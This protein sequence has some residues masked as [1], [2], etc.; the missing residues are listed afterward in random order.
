MAVPYTFGTA[1][2]AIPLSNLDSNFATT[3]TLGNTAIQLGNTVTTLNN[4]TLANVT[5]SSGN[6]TL[7]NVA[8]TTANVTTANIGTAIITGTTTLT[9]LTASTALSLDA[10]KN[11]AS[12][13]NTGTGNNVLSASP[14]LTG[15]V[16]GASLSL[17]SLT[18]GR[19][20]YATT[21][22]LLTDSANMT[23]DGN[24]LA[25][26]SD[27]TLPTLS[28]LS[29]SATPN[30]RLGSQAN[31]AVYWQIGRDNVTT[32]D[33]IF[34]TQ[35]AE[36]VRF[37]D[38]GNVGIGATTATQRLH[39]SNSAAS[40]DAFAQFTNGTTGTAA[41]NG[42]F[43]GVDS[44]NEASVYNFYNSGLKFATNAIERMRID[45]SGNVGINN[46]SPTATLTV[47][48]NVSTAKVAISVGVPGADLSS[49]TLVTSGTNMNGII[50]GVAVGSTN[51]Y[52]GG[53]WIDNGTTQAGIASTR[54]ATANWG[55]DLRFYTHPAN[56]SNVNT[57]TEV[58][59]FDPSGNLLVGVTSANAN[60]GVL[61]LK[62]GITFPATQSASTDANTLDDYEEGTWT[63][64]IAFGGG[65]TG[66]TYTVNTGRYIKIGSSVTVTG[67]LLLSS[68]GSSTG[69]ATLTGL[70]YTVGAGN[71]SSSV[72]AIRLGNITFVG[73]YHG[74]GGLGTTVV[75]L[76][77][78]NGVT[79]VPA[80]LTDTNF[81]N[82][83]I[84]QLSYTYF[85]D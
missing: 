15:T 54:P 52:G 2:A 7:T 76:G 55:S 50:T 32:G 51:G 47:G 10:S 69:N 25:L 82:N 24:T 43:V 80:S 49:S 75:D 23:Y 29:N 14:T 84:V 56:T 20:P 85:V 11:I 37:T 67:F 48:T 63:M 61:Q 73:Q 16:A 72:A 40:S 64:G 65:T 59:R 38:S 79:G 42:L 5:V 68:K 57:T 83:G 62:S 35:T 77:V 53:Y 17:S 33:F 26:R 19:V 4:M 36:R 22:G 66:I 18:S 30:L 74:V 34:S 39:I 78:D 81:P 13:T 71:P 45:S 60:G 41:V 1:T 9:N 8:V 46:S 70:P 44:S 12:V 21:A 3:I 58:G 6:V 28:V 27:T 31:T